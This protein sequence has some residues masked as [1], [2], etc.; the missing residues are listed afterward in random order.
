MESLNKQLFLD[1]NQFAGHNH[2]LDSVMMAAATV[3]P[4]LFIAVLFYLWFS[5]RRN[6]A[7]YAGYTTTL[8]IVINSIIGLVYFHPRPFME[9]LGTTLLSHKAD[10]SF[11]SDHTTF[12]LSIALMLVTFKSTRILGI[13]LSVLALWCGIARVYA[14][15]HWPFDIVGSIVTATI[16]TIVIFVLKAKLVKLNDIIIEIWNKIF[17]DKNASNNS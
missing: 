11:P 8:G 16:A 2:L 4:Y 1:I 7:L 5:H 14:G 12:T 9:K 17:K 6:E 10:S 13:V 15:V 3:M